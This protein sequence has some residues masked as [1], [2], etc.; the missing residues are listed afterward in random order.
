[1]NL[2]PGI[3]TRTTDGVIGTSG[4]PIRVF[5]IHLISGGT[6]SVLAVHNGTSASD[7]QILS[8]TG[9]ISTGATFNFAGGA[10]FPAGCYVN[11]DTNISNVTFS[12]TEEF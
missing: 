4:K 8:L 10:R 7:T 11:V 12:Y 1:M 5:W 2:I 9:T 3:Q 6:A